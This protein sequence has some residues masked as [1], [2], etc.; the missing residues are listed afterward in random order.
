MSWSPRSSQDLSLHDPPPINIAAC[1]AVLFWFWL[2]SHCIVWSVWVFFPELL[3]KILRPPL[4]HTVFCF[5]RHPS[6]SLINISCT[7]T[8]FPMAKGDINI[9]DLLANTLTTLQLFSV[10]HEEPTG[11]FHPFPRL[12]T[13]LR[14]KIFKHAL[15]VPTVLDVV[16][17]V[18]V[19]DPSFGLY[20]T[21]SLPSPRS[22]RGNSGR[23]LTSLD[24]RLSPR[25]S[26]VFSLLSVN[27]ESRDLYL[28]VYSI[29]LPC[30]KESQSRHGPPRGILHVS[31][32]EILH[33]DKLDDLMAELSFYKALQNNY[34]LQ[35]FWGQIENIAVPVASFVLSD[36]KGAKCKGLLPL[37]CLK[38]TGLKSLKGVMWTG[39]QELQAGPG[40]EMMQKSMLRFMATAETAL[41]DHQSEHKDYRVPDFELIH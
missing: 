32:Q 34:R 8:I 29:A 5:P 10:P 30:Q 23:N 14:L 3:H 15:P 12:P 24:E 13:E 26:R 21:F 33:W 37:L 41:K 25:Q 1:E 36:L 19:S 11:L 17:T 18:V 40:R 28:S 6:T 7:N 39:F 16:A 35:D 27:K 38:L 9:T 2:S 20:M 31:K 4:G 22:F